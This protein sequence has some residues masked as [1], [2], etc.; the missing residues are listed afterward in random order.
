MTGF[1]NDKSVRI[2]KD[3][4]G[5]PVVI[6]SK[7]GLQTTSPGSGIDVTSAT[8]DQFTFNSEQDIF[9]IVKKIKS[10]IP[11]FSWVSA[12]SASS[13]LTVAHGQSVTP[14]IN[15]YVSGQLIN[16]STSSVLSSTY[17]PVPIFGNANTLY[18]SFYDSAQ[19]TLWPLAILTGV[20][21]T[22]VYVEAIYNRSTA[23]T[24]NV[25]AIPT[26]IFILQETAT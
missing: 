20:D 11:A 15:V 2:I 8:N 25:A 23:A 1:K 3:D 4:T 10:N 5:T 21:S 26:T 12:T 7:N 13:L 18:Y 17:I 14:L 22:N 6:L 24:G 19:T 16:F 9:K